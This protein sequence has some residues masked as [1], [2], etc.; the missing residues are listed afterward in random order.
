MIL[1]Q[2]I[3]DCTQTSLIMRYSRRICS[4][5]DHIQYS[6]NNLFE[7]VQSYNIV[8]VRIQL[9]V[10]I[11]KYYNFCLVNF[12]RSCQFCQIMSNIVRFLNF[13]LV[14]YFTYTKITD[15]HLLPV[16]TNHW[17]ALTITLH[18]S[19]SLSITHYYPLSPL[20]HSHYQILPRLSL[21]RFQFCVI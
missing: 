16:N 7:S 4:I 18:H 6:L 13:S 3:R 19:L 20:S 1:K 15:I 17:Q 9:D 21:M 5:S 14:D 11:Y 8:F 10:L 12:V 2:N